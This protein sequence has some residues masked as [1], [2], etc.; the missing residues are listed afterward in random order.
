MPLKSGKA[1][2]K[3]L[4]KPQGFTLVELMIVVAVV[5][6][7]AALSIPLYQGYIA[8]SQMH[9]A[10]GELS[11]YKAAYEER[12]SMGGSVTNQDL[13]YVPSKIT[14]GTLGADIA[15]LNA[16]GTGHLRVTL[17]GNAHPRLTGVTITLER[18]SIGVWSCIVDNTAVV[19]SWEST[20]LPDNCRL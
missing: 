15:V 13:G 20:F 19:G 3:M 5:G 4:F 11:G 14:K 1:G 10:V 16:D 2:D 18:S 8:N 9:R 12:V 6:I 7:L 17:G